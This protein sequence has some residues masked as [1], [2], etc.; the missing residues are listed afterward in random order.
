MPE[1]R[2]GPFLGGITG[3]PENN[4]QV[5][6]DDCQHFDVFT[7]PFLL[8]PYRDLEANEDKTFTI[9]DFEYAN[10][11][12]FGQGRN[13]GDT[14]VK[15]YEKASNAIDDDWTAATGSEAASVGATNRG[16]FKHYKNYIYGV[17]ANTSVYRWGDIT[18][19]PTFT[20]GFGTI[21][22]VSGKRVSEG[23]IAK[24]DVLYI[25]HDT[26]L[27]SVDDSATFTAVAFD[28]P[29]EITSLENWG[30]YLA[31]ATKGDG[32]TTNSR[33]FLWNLIDADPSEVVDW[34]REELFLIGRLGDAL[35]GV[36]LTEGTSLS[37]DQSL[38]IKR[39]AGGQ[40][41]EVIFQKNL[42]GTGYS[43]TKHRHV[44]DNRISFGLS[45]N[46]NSET[47]KGIWAI[48]RKNAKF[49]VIV[50]HEI[51]AINDE[52]ITTIENFFKLGDHYFIA[53]STDGSVDRTDNAANFTATSFVETEIF[54]G[55]DPT[56]EKN[57][58]GVT[59]SY[60]PLP[61][62]GQAV[63]KVKVNRASSW[64]TVFTETTNDATETF[65]T[66]LGASTHFN[67]FKEIQ[68]RIESTGKAE[69]LGL[70]AEWEFTGSKID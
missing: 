17:R 67:R 50:N 18:G 41:A 47:N 44:E 66:R 2:F 6:F 24:D 16:T 45:K 13:T 4:T 32:I 51:K 65:E 48:G 37:F 52:A 30:N 5:S 63:L 42:G 28:L 34:G 43:I 64:S 60:K 26:D 39:W 23:I 59:V 49:P 7:N 27:A 10:D 35:Y 3:E 8:T 53:H 33:V 31:I 15:I 54:N 12:L 56:K 57:M 55:G 69:I 58:K 9:T 25:P 11:T 1:I 61:A 29:D 19:T 20:E 62:N 38:V 36:S 68:F 14:K 21:S 70:R 40:E 22:S 46:D